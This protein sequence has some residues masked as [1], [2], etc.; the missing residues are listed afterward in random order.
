MCV[1]DIFENELECVLG[2]SGTGAGR[3][4]T[5]TGDGSALNDCMR[6]I[7]GDSISTMG[8]RFFGVTDTDEASEQSAR[9]SGLDSGRASLRFGGGVT[10]R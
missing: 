9:G 1:Y 5:F 3:G 2:V 7:D 10:E 6:L 4:V 8:L